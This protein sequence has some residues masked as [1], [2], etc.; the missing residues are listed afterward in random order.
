MKT[1][2]N[3][4]ALLARLWLVAALLL[5]AFLPAQA[6]PEYLYSTNGATWGWRTDDFAPSAGAKFQIGT[7]DV[8]VTH[9]GY[10]DKDADG[11]ANAH[12]VGIY[13]PP[14]ANNLL[15]EVLVPAATDAFY[16]NGFRWVQLAPPLVLKAG[17]NYIVCAQA[18]SG[19]ERMLKECATCLPR[20]GGSLS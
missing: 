11:L 4:N 5:G 18:P 3:L 7:N 19:G 2:R 9:L 12:P 10:F 16:T 20:H 14:G 8:I 15:A 6:Q 1:T 17:S 13:G